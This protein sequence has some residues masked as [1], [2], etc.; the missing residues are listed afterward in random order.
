MHEKLNKKRLVKAVVAAIAVWG[1]FIGMYF[2]P[3]LDIPIP[4]WLEVIAGA[5]FLLLVTGGLFWLFVC[6]FY[7]MIGLNEEHKKNDEL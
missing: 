7:V 5:C 6:I 2:M 4:Y 3:K 1:F